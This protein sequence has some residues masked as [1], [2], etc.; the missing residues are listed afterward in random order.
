MISIERSLAVRA[1]TFGYANARVKA[2]KQSL[3]SSRETQALAEAKDNEELF[4]LLERTSYKHDLVSG[5]L[6]EKTIP[7]QIELACSHNFSGTLEKIIQIT[8]KKHREKIRKLF[9][10]Y[11]IN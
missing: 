7:D 2:M 9:E 4:V 1:L 8:P 3:L 11:E 10:K 5:A 6:R